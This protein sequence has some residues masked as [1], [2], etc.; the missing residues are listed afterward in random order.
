MRPSRS[1]FAVGDIDELSL[2]VS[3][4]VQQYRVCSL[5]GSYAGGLHEPGRRS[6]V[7]TDLFDGRT[8][9]SIDERVSDRYGRDVDG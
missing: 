1:S 6:M 8:L 5:V 9:C 3:N 7:A 2:V 4:A